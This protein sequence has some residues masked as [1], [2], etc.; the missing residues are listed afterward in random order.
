MGAVWPRA[1]APMGSISR[2][3]ARKLTMLWSFFV[4]IAMLRSTFLATI[5]S[6]FTI[7]LRTTRSFSTRGG[8]ISRP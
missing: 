2:P 7:A 3:Q 1:V 4:A 8:S 6:T 5:T